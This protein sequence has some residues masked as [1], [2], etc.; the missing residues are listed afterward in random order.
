MK[1]RSAFEWLKAYGGIN[2]ELTSK[3][4]EPKLQILDNEA[5]TALK[6]YF[7]ENDVEY[8]L[9]PPHCSA[10]LKNCEVKTP[11]CLLFFC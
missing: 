10:A 1:S 5:S 6:S 3:G 8:Q 9:V 2:Q 7:T 4:F 11:K